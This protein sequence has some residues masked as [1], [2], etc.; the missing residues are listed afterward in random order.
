[1][2][3]HHVSCL[4]QETAQRKHR[5]PPSPKIQLMSNTQ[6]FQETG[7]GIG[8]ACQFDTRDMLIV[9]KITNKMKQCHSDA[10]MHM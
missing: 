10:N 3:I 9:T 2:G 8:K 5:T 4:V 6:E 7:T 1:M